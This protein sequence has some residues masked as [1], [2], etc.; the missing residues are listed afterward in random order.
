MATYVPKMSAE[1]IAHLRRWHEDASAELH[2]LGGHDVDYLGLRL[3]VPEH[4]FPPTPTSDLLGRE[5]RSR[6]L[7]GKRVL[8]MGCGAGANAILA[9]QITDQVVAVDVNP[10]AVEATTANAGRNGVSERIG[11]FRS[12]VFAEV[13]GDF[14]VI[15]V[16]PPFRWFAP[17]DLLEQAVADEDYEMLGR[18]IAEV[19][20]R[21]RPGG[22]VLLFFGTSGDVDH[23]DC[24]I[25]DAD[26]TSLTVADRTIR[27]R[28]EDVTY[29]VR[30]ITC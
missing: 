28:G 24:L 27:A 18:F 25:S 2:G 26:L 10:H 14:D 6:V 20:Q 15:V 30:Q 29:F 16:D 1:R 4:V 7:S 8:D 3:H 13:E 17:R 19:G 11:C 21:L 12:D 23:L 9:A 22:F 5:V